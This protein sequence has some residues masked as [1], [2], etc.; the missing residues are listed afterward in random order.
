MERGKSILIEGTDCSGKETQSKL[1]EKFLKEQGI[2]VERFGYPVYDSPTGKIVGGP[3]LGK[4]Y[5]CDGW[6]P[7][8]A[9]N[10]DPKVSA[11]YYGADFLYHLNEMNEVLDSGKW[12]ILDRYFYSTFAH[13]GGKELDKKKR[14]ELYKWFKS[15]FIDLLNLPDPDIKLFL[16]MPYECS[17]ILK[18]GREE[19]ADQNEKDANHLKNAEKAYIEMAKLYGFK[20]IKCGEGDT[21][22]T[23]EE[24]HKDVVKVLKKTL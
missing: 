14:L 1:L 4:E 16:H 2:E 19:A 18:Q 13:Q 9:P 20:T 22:R 8:G 24:I 5:I 15:Y 7:E 10:V 17:L 6:F 23:V 12:I 21:P 3:Y 11:Q